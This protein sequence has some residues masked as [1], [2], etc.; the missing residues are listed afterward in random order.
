VAAKDLVSSCD[1][2]NPVKKIPPWTVVQ[3]CCWRPTALL[4]VAPKKPSA[5]SSPCS[6]TSQLSHSTNDG[7]HIRPEW[8]VFWTTPDGTYASFEEWITA[9]EYSADRMGLRQRQGIFH[10]KESRHGGLIAFRQLNRGRI[11]IRIS[12]FRV[13]LRM[14]QL[15]YIRGTFW[16]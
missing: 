4:A 7:L 5:S 16:S 1:P 13:C 11:S 8:R 15:F 12:L 10:R 2:V 3:R 14:V 9:W 6:H